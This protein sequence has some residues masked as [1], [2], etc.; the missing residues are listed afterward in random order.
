MKGFG[1]FLVATALTLAVALPASARVATKAEVKQRLLVMMS[2]FEHV[3][4]RAD[5][6]RAGPTE[7]VAEALVEIAEDGSARRSLR[8]R[9]ISGMRHAPTPLVR[10]FL[11]QAVENPTT[12]PLLRRKAAV[13]LGAVSREDA[14]L[15]LTPLLSADDPFLREAVLRGIAEVP[16]KVATKT[17]KDHVALEKTPSV[18]RTAQG[19]LAARS[20]KAARP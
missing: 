15:V 11:K 9:A 19:L 8:A 4:T 5:W 14:L 16:G 1:R 7:R 3:P 18:R 12:L 20:R 17:I 10:Q 6:R 13:S 2:G